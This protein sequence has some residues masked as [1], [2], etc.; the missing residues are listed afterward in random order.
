MCT[1][2]STGV[3]LV[4]SCVHGGVCTIRQAMTHITASGRNIHY[5]SML[6]LWEDQ[7]ANTPR[8]Q[9][10]DAEQERLPQD[11]VA[12]IAAVFWALTCSSRFTYASQSPHRTLTARQD[13]LLGT[14]STTIPDSHVTRVNCVDHEKHH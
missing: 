13:L 7:D 8:D 4:I 11:K 6:G 12:H 14:L 10:V 5:D 3:R 1:L 2:R 9:R